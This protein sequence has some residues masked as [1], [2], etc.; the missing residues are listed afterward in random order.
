M[1]KVAYIK[2]DEQVKI[3]AQKLAQ[4]LG[5]SLS[6]VINAQL[7]QFVR[8]KRIVV[9][10]IP[11]MSSYLEEL[12]GPIEHDMQSG[13]NLSQSITSVEELNKVLDQA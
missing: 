10:A 8:D 9:S 13:K 11:T 12:L 5:F 6:T 4:E 3:Q 1:K 7:K 2:L